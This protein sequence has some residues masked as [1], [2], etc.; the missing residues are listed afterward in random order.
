MR[1][2][3]VKSLPADLTEGASAWRASAY[4]LLHKYIELYMCQLRSFPR[5]HQII[6]I[7]YCHG[8]NMIPEGYP[9]AVLNIVPPDQKNGGSIA[10]DP[11]NLAHLLGMLHIV[12][13][14]C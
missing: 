5:Y 3:G 14:I 7:M 8:C 10:D 9:L 6:I 2:P 11:I 1:P 13:L 4:T 12:D